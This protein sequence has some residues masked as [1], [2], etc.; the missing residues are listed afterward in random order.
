VRP[1]EPTPFEHLVVVPLSRTEW[2]VSEVSNDGALLGF[3]ERQASNR[4]EVVWMTDPMRWG[5]TGTFDEAVTAFGDSSR[6]TGEIFDERA[7]VAVGAR[8]APSSDRGPSGA[9]R[10]TWQSP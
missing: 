3:I 1:T 4:F 9:R 10:A 8:T 5:Y 7:E 6:F 2:R